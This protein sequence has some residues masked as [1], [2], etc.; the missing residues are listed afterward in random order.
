MLSGN[1]H[2]DQEKK[3]NAQEIGEEII[4]IM[5]LS[6][7]INGPLFSN[8]SD[9]KQ[10]RS[11]C[12][13]VMELNAKMI[14]RAIESAPNDLIK[15]RFESE[16]NKQLSDEEFKTMKEKIFNQPNKIRKLAKKINQ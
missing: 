2:G 5:S 7:C 3:K 15:K 4:L 8:I 12:L 11:E 6:T 9:E 13:N 16:F 1:Q 14:A 10:R